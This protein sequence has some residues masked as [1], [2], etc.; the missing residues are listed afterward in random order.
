M[1]KVIDASG[2]TAPN[3]L[4][5]IRGTALRIERAGRRLLD[6]P[7]FEVSG[8][9]TLVLLG[10]NGAGKTLLLKVLANLVTPDAGIV[11]W[12][13]RA[14]D[15]ARALKLGFV[16]Q[17]PVLLR[18]STLANVMYPLAVAG[19]EKPEQWSRAMRALRLAG[20]EALADTPARVLSGGEQRRVAIARALVTDPDVLFL[21]EPTANL[22]PAATSAVEALIRSV[23]ERGYPVVLVTH[24]IGQA[25][26]L[27][28]EAVLMAGGRI[29]EQGAA[30]RF[31]AAPQSAEAKAYLAGDIVL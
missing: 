10:P 29:A 13:G 15:R 4:L 19:V 6:C 9:G 30:D 28:D 3:E 20:L 5:P 7:A 31:F 22:D 21:D 18:R 23:K 2:L 17:K 1:L 11:T 8:D 12:A 26:R 24:D 14:P 25:R 27:A 16:L